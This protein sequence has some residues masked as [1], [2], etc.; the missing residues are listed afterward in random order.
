MAAILSSV[1]AYVIVAAAAFG[2]NIVK[3]Y[4]KDIDEAKIVNL[5]RLAV[6]VISLLAFL[7]SL[8][9][10]LVFSI[11]LLAAAGLGSSFGPLVLFSLY[12]RDINKTGAIASIIVGLVVVIFWYYGGFSAYIYELVP[13]FIASCLALSVGTR[14]GGGADEETRELYD[15]YISKLKQNK[16]RG[17]SV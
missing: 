4:A 15:R 16:R 10:N 5:E 12:S 8:K 7:M 2:A 14:L 6:V 11:A 9:S 3:H 17:E 1:N 13:G